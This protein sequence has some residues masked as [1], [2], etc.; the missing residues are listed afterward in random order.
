M[1]IGAGTSAEVA[2]KIAFDFGKVLRE[3]GAEEDD[4]A[5]QR[6][7]WVDRR[8]A[9]NPLLPYIAAGFEAGY[10]NKPLPWVR[11]IDA[12]RL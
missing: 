7:I 6:L 4:C 2:I 3:S 5:H 1:H 11:Q 10:L 12:V 9:A 8:Y